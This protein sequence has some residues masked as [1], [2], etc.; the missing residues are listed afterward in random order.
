[1]DP[2]LAL[3]ERQNWNIFRFVITSHVARVQGRTEVEVCRRR[4]ST[5]MRAALHPPLFPGPVATNDTTAADIGMTT[6]P[7]L[8][9]PSALLLPVPD[10]DLFGWS[11]PPV[12]TGRDDALLAKLSGKSSSA[13]TAN[14]L[15]LLIIQHR[16]PVPLVEGGRR[17][18]ELKKQVAHAHRCAYPV[19]RSRRSARSSRGSAA[20]RRSSS[21]ASRAPLCR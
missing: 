15:R 10:D 3:A 19:R 6:P 5:A 2:Y 4:V 9:P 11:A 20:G 13:L 12:V 17:L 18:A 14:D 8:P 7:S 16:L 1:M 21:R